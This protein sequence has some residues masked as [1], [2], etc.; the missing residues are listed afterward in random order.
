MLKI[1]IHDF[2]GNIRQNEKVKEINPLIIKRLIIDDI[3]ES[4]L[5]KRV[6]IKL[7]KKTSKTLNIIFKNFKSIIIIN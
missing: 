2:D 4:T 1:Q 6:V 7:V 5:I 3:G